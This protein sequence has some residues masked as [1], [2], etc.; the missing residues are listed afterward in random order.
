M[1]REAYYELLSGRYWILD[2]MFPLI[3][4]DKNARV[5]DYVYINIQT[6]YVATIL[7]Y[8]YPFS[9][10]CPFLLSSP[11]FVYYVLFFKGMILF[12]K[13]I[14]LLLFLLSK[15]FVFCWHSGPFP[16]FVFMPFRK[17]KTIHKCVTEY[18][19]ALHDTEALFTH[20]KVDFF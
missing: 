4:C 17:N 15:S 2:N 14:I 1:R 10:A 11:T 3:Y 9:R 16:C 19:S 6:Q 20:F 8:I 7:K 13:K 12:H 18:R 5:T